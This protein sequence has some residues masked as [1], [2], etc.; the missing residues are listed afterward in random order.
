MKLEK[1]EKNKRYDSGK[2]CPLCNTE[3][4]IGWEVK[5]NFYPMVDGDSCYS[6]IKRNIKETFL[7]CMYCNI[8]IYDEE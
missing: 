3:M 6:Y 8:R 5:F 1:V 7:E 4:S 2:K